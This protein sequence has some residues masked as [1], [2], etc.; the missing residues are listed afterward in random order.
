MIVFEESLLRTI[1]PAGVYA[2]ETTGTFHLIL[3]K[4]DVYLIANDGLVNFLIL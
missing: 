4:S 1:F 2:K 3:S